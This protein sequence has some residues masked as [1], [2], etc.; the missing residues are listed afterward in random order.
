M[1]VCTCRFTQLEYN[2]ATMSNLE[3][4][5]P[6][7]TRAEMLEMLMVDV[8]EGYEPAMG[9]H[10]WEDHI[11]KGLERIDDLEASGIA[12]DIEDWFIVRAAYIGHDVFLTSTKKDPSLLEGFS[13]PE[14]LS[15]EKTKE[16][17][18]GYGLNQE[19]VDKV[20]YCIMA[21]NPGQPC[22]TPEA[23]AVCRVD[24]GNIGDS[25]DVFL[26]NFIQVQIED[27]RIDQIMINPLAVVRASCDFLA[28]YMKRSTL[29]LGPEDSFPSRVEQNLSGL[30]AMGANAIRNAF[31]NHTSSAD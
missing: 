11:V 19:T 5:D 13:C 4:I 15:A 8:R 6:V 29:A 18:L 1:A 21:T 26:H 30:R 9:Y 25:F 28:L 17:L 27:K 23:R 24:I 20:Y 7:P 3:S 2:F 14:E 31:F 22:E 16:L 10:N 12:T